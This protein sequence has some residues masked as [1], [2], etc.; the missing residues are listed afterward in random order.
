MP[1]PG[2][3]QRATRRSGS[4]GVLE[5]F[6]PEEIEWRELR[7]W[8]SP[9]TGVEYTGCNGIQLTEQLLMSIARVLLLLDM[10][11]RHVIVLPLPLKVPEVIP[12]SRTRNVVL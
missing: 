10:K 7:R 5:T 1:T 3:A 4:D 6:L 8:R 9:R 12:M 11:A 2:N